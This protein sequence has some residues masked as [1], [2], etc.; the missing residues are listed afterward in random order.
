MKKACNCNIDISDV[1]LLKS[2]TQ[3]RED[4]YILITKKE[5]RIVDNTTSSL[6]IIAQVLLALSTLGAGL[7]PTIYDD[8]SAYGFGFCVLFV[9]C[10]FLGSLYLSS[11]RKTTLNEILKLYE[12]QGDIII[13]SG[14]GQENLKKVNHE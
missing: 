8:L 4:E 11:K 12:K 6:D 1:G 5:L 14:S 13:P 7:L 3:L 10:I 9:I 2:R